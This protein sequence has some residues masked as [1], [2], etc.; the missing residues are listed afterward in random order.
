MTVRCIARHPVVAFYALGV[1]TL[2][3][4]A[5]LLQSVLR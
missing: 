4:V 2:A 1:S 3:G 5:Y